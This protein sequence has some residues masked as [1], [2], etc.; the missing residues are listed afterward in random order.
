M[1]DTQ[2]VTLLVL[3]ALGGMVGLIVGLAIGQAFGAAGKV[4]GFG[5]ALAGTAASALYL[6]P[7]VTPTVEDVLGDMLAPDPAEE[8]EAGMRSNPLIDAYFTRYPDETAAHISRLQAVLAQNGGSAVDREIARLG[9]QVELQTYGRAVP[10]APDDS[11][12]A[13][14]DRLRQMLALNR[15]D[16]DF[17]RAYGMRPDMEAAAAIY[18][19]DGRPRRSHSQ[20]ATICCGRSEPRCAQPARKMNNG[21]GINAGRAPMKNISARARF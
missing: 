7:M 10:L 15:T 17:C 6:A 4:F 3:G 1:E 20:S 19:Q 16:P 13:V 18:L 8:I 11:V 21:I 12:L 2:L 5:L 9:R 14:F